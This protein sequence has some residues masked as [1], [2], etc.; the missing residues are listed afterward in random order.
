[1]LL[2][3]VAF[4]TTVIF[5][6]V[7]MYSAGFRT[8]QE[9]NTVGSKESSHLQL[10]T[11]TLQTQCKAWTSLS[12]PAQQCAPALVH[13]TPCK[14]SVLSPELLDPFTA[15]AMLAQLKQKQEKAMNTA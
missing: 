12:P 11:P 2:P 3:Q 5:V 10:M 9:H 4:L 13:L 6:Q 1:M 15:L 8:C 7:S 14:P